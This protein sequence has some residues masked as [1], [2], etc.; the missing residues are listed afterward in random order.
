MSSVPFITKSSGV[1]KVLRQNQECTFC[2][3]CSDIL[4]WLV[5][6]QSHQ[7][8]K[9]HLGLYANDITHNNIA[10]FSLSLLSRGQQVSAEKEREVKHKNVT[11]F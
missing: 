10:F 1:G 5:Y 7:I 11:D 9:M 2:T 6:L 8:H 3:I 4:S